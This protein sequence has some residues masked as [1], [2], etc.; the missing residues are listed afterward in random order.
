MHYETYHF[1]G[2]F[3]NM[4][5]Q[6]AGWNSSPP[7]WRYKQT[8][9]VKLQ[10]IALQHAWAHVY[11]FPSLHQ[12]T[13]VEWE[14][15]IAKHFV[16]LN[17]ISLWLKT[18]F[19]TWVQGVNES[20]WCCCFCLD[21]CSSCHTQP[22]ILI[23]MRMVL[24]SIMRMTRMGMIAMMMR[25]MRMIT[26][27]SKRATGDSNVP[28]PPANT[29]LKQGNSSWEL[30]VF[31][32]YLKVSNPIGTLQAL[33]SRSCISNTS[34]EGSRGAFTVPSR[35]SIPHSS[36]GQTKFTNHTWKHLKKQFFF[37]KTAVKT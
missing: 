20:W 26:F 23:K 5:I 24:R 21:S 4:T 8:N 29:A 3:R 7:F 22:N 16:Q 1:Q 18:K 6:F 32:I 2:K 35:S 37:S 36:P 19:K 17:I 9:Q 13:H 33:L 30:S 10:I 27:F 11:W 12:L 14:S 31:M 25:M 34:R 15:E 28:L